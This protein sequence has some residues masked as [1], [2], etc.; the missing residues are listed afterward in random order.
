MVRFEISRI[1]LTGTVTIFGRGMIA[2][3]STR[4]NCQRH[5]RRFSSHVHMWWRCQITSIFRLEF[6]IVLKV[7]FFYT[8]ILWRTCNCVL[9]CF[10][11]M[12]HKQI[13]IYFWKTTYT[14][15]HSMFSVFIYFLCFLLFC[16]C[17]FVYWWVSIS[18]FCVSVCVLK[19]KRNHTDAV[20]F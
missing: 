14:R 18:F 4:A 6:G 16:W 15:C 13:K 19:F 9:L 1:D 5:Y 20:N 12:K 10:Y 8:I 2:K 17:L 7:W 11:V 3:I